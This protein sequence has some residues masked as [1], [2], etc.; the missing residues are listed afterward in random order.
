MMKL[1]KGLTLSLLMLAS[2]CAMQGAAGVAPLP[3]AAAGPQEIT[4]QATPQRQSTISI[5]A[6]ARPKGVVLFSHGASG[7]PGSY[8]QLHQRLNAAGY[9]VLA[10]LHV[11]SRRH[12]AVASYNLQTAFEERIA[13][14]A[15]VARLAEERFPGLPVAAMGHSYGALLAQM[16]GGA[17]KYISDARAPAVKAVVSFSSP[18]NISGL[19]QPPAYTTLA[20]PTLM[21]TGTAD[22]VPG[23]VADWREHVRPHND[24][25]AGGRYLMTI[26]DGD[27]FIAVAR[28]PAHF[29]RAADA[30]IAFLDAFLL[31]DA[32][33]RRR[34]D[35][36]GLERR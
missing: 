32:S 19:I 33:A 27:H 14:M 8:P 36:A 4:V 15:A 2:G 3:I 34:L 20:V 26:P 11:D 31:G 6:P 16:Q 13:D 22:T 12:P 28:N 10:P 17:L 24:A 18:G 9:A 5:Y 7:E 30:A 21:I 25:P 1:T 29:Q 35:S 23:F